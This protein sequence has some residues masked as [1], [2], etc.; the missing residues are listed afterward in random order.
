MH[1]S[2]LRSK[3]KALDTFKV[4]KAK[5]ENQCGKHIKIMRSDEVESTMVNT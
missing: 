2:L 3:D 1:V 5:V 4:F